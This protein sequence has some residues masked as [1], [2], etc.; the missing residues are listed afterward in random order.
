MLKH[1]SVG[2][3]EET[4]RSEGG[5]AYH[6]LRDFAVGGIPCRP[7]HGLMCPFSTLDRVRTK[8]EAL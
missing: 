3:I 5:P 8:S 2:Q 4:D 7:I 6:V 1:T